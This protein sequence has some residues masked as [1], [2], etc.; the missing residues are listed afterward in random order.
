MTS[1]EQEPVP[2]TLGG[3][4]FNHLLVAYDGSRS[5]EL[6]L[7]A[8]VT[9]A[10]RDNASI[11]LLAVVPDVMCELAR[12]PSPC[13]PDPQALQREA[14]AEAAARLAIAITRVPDGIPVS[15][16]VRRGKAGR[17]IVAQTEEVEYDAVILGARGVGKIGTILGSVSNHVLHHADTSVFV[18]HAP[19]ED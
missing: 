13:P 10:Q 2:R 8:A 14:D 19:R 5:A 1:T 9:A 12:W 11:T 3:L 4:R 6:A 16:V 7:S 18:A 15:T 17:E